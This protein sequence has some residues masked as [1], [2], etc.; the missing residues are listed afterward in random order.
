MRETKEIQP[1]PRREV[2]SSRWRSA[3][4]PDNGSNSSKGCGPSSG[5]SKDNAHKRI[6]LTRHAW[7]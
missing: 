3:E 5:A 2:E 4:R 1:T 6:K 7:L